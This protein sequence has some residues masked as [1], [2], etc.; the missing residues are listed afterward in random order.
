LGPIEIE[1]AEKATTVSLGVEYNFTN[2]LYN[3]LAK[4]FAPQVAEKLVKAFEKR[5]IEKVG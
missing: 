1:K 4:K 3:S 5:A 2:P